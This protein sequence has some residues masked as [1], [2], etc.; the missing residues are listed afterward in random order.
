MKTFGMHLKYFLD[1]TKVKSVIAVEY[2][3]L[4]DVC[5]TCLESDKK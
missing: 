1:N 5:L 3:D 2:L 4:P